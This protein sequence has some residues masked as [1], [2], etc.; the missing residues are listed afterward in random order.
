M[1]L[2]MII[3]LE[4]IHTEM[5]H[6]KKIVHSKRKHVVGE[7][8]LFLLLRLYYQEGVGR[9]MYQWLRKWVQRQI[10]VTLQNVCMKNATLLQQH[11]CTKK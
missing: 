3:S 9:N 10:I 7:F 11:L 4:K 8:V 2:N 5:K 1:Q 6:R